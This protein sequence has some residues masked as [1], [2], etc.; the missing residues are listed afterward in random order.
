MKSSLDAWD[1][2]QVVEQSPHLL[3]V[4]SKTMHASPSS[5]CL[6]C[7]P[8]EKLLAWALPYQSDSDHNSYKYLVTIALGRALHTADL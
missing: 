7:K 5:D 4:A 1:Q 8:A 2:T 6:D 3:I